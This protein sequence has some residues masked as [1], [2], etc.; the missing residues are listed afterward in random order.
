MFLSCVSLNNGLRRR[1]QRFISFRLQ[2][3]LNRFS[4][5]NRLCWPFFYGI[6]FIFHRYITGSQ[7]CS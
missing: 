4:V 5:T 2:R 6:V 7:S 1:W 3:G